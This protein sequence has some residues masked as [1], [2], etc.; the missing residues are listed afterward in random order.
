LAEVRQT[1]G[2]PLIETEDFTA[3]DVK[4]ITAYAMKEYKRLSL[5]NTIK[6]PGKTLDTLLNEP[7]IAAKFIKNIIS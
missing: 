2:N 5:I 7:H 1:Q 3:E 6:Y 4:E